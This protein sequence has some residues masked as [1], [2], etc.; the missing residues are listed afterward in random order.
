MPEDWDKNQSSEFI[1]YQFGM[2]VTLLE[3]QVPRTTL[4]G[5]AETSALTWHMM[6]QVPPNGENSPYLPVL[7]CMESSSSI[8]LRILKLLKQPLAEKPWMSQ[9]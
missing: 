5:Q 9:R 6:L 8:T 4:Q 2:S 1:C 7:I 3:V